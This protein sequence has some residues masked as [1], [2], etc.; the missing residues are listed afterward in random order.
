[1]AD[2][3]WM[4][5]YSVDYEGGEP[6]A[7]WKQKPVMEQIYAL[8]RNGHDCRHKFTQKEATRIV[9]KGFINGHGCNYDLIEYE[10]ED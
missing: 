9:Q 8:G 5:E 1:M 3:F 7:F 4:L 10:F 6:V 2:K